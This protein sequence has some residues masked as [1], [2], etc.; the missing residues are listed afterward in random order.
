MALSFNPTPAEGEFHEVSPGKR[1]RFTNGAWKLHINNQPESEQMP[2]PTIE[3]ATPPAL[4]NAKKYWF[5]TTTGRMHYQ[6]NDGDSVQWVE[7]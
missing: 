2:M 6:Y 5:N 1:Y 3:S 7:I 4:P